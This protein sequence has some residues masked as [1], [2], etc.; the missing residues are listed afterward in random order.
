MGGIYIRQ[1][2]WVNKGIW[3]GNEYGVFKGPVKLG[4]GWR[5][6]WVT[7]LEN[8]PYS[9]TMEIEKKRKTRFGGEDGHLAVKICIPTTIY[10]C[11]YLLWALSGC[12][13]YNR[14]Q[15]RQTQLSWSLDFWLQFLFSVYLNRSLSL[16]SLC[17]PSTLHLDVSSV[18]LPKYTCLL[19]Y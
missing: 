15:N 19:D 12:M 9:S 13:G 2:V 5:G 16:K 18:S 17:A 10:W 11:G 3:L 14:G 1:V 7:H 8:G 4:S 6:P